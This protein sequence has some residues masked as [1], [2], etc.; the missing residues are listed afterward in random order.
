MLTWVGM[1]A[2]QPKSVSR[3]T[4]GNVRGGA[5][6]LPGS[7]EKLAAPAHDF[8]DHFSQIPNGNIGTD[9]DTDTDTDAIGRIIGAGRNT[10]ASARSSMNR[11]DRTC[12]R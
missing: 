3:E 5:V 10:I 12:W 11:G 1:L 4:P 2:F 6:R 7:E 8:G 9:T